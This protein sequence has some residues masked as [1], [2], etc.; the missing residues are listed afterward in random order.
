M[1]GNL[2]QGGALE[3]GRAETQGA[4]GKADLGL[5]VTPSQYVKHDRLGEKDSLT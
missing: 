4:E 2:L 5:C 1:K 3:R